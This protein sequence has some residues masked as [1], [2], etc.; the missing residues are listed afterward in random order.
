MLLTSF[1]VPSLPRHHHFVNPVRSKRIMGQYWRILNLDKRVAI[2]TYKLGEYLLT[3]ET[4]KLFYLFAVPPLT[5]EQDS[6]GVSPF[7]RWAGDQIICIGDYARDYPDSI[8]DHRGRVRRDGRGAPQSTDGAADAFPVGA[9][10][11]RNLTKRVYVLAARLKT[12]WDREQGLPDDEVDL[13]SSDAG[14][15]LGNVILSRVC[16]SSDPSCSLHEEDS[17]R[18]YRGVWAG[19][20]FD[21]VTLAALDS[22]PDAELW[23]DISEEIRE[24]VGLLWK[25]DR[26]VNPFE[27]AED[28]QH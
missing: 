10:V 1:F 16:W 19:D 25:H 11:L 7:G 2:K 13:G 9:W 14:A 23:E 24:E 6:S 17:K 22:L 3:H 4:N 12:P 8:K 5:Q 15:F 20:R 21:I 27:P 28:A 26:G 18:I